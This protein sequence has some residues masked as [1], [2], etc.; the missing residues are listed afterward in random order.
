L[1]AAGREV[2][3]PHEGPLGFVPALAEPPRARADVGVDAT[4]LGDLDELEATDFAVAAY[5]DDGVWHVAPLPERAHEDLTALTHA[6][7]QRPPQSSPLA[8]VAVDDDFW[9]AARAR[10]SDVRLLLSDATAA[11]EWPLA[12]EVLDALGEALPDDDEPRPVGDLTLFAD[13]GLRRPALLELCD[14]E[15]YPDEVC[16]RV[17]DQLGF[18]HQLVRA[19]RTA[20]RPAY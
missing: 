15:L 20:L 4:L 16:V 6:L 1:V 9:V 3:V 10:G 17:A 11:F 14:D 5:R 2:D 18:G 7:L 8:L 19:L 12:R 13:L